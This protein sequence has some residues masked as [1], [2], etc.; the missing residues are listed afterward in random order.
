MSQRRTTV[1]TATVRDCSVLHASHLRLIVEESRRFL[2][3]AAEAS[4]G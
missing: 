1:C 4:H 2:Q 3:R